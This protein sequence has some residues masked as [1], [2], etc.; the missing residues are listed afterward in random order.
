MMV[1]S[2]VN[3]LKFKL[4]HIVWVF[5]LEQRKFLKCR[6][7]KDLYGADRKTT[8]QQSHVESSSSSRRSI[9]IYMHK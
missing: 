7:F 9:H 1:G 8:R 6:E 2:I 3:S 4:Q 5:Y